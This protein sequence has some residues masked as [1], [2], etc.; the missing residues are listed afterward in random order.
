M[1]E[2]EPHHEWCV[3]HSTKVSREPK[4]KEGLEVSLNS[5]PAAHHSKANTREA[6][7]GG[8]ERLLYAGGWQP[9]EEVD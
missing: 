9:V 3:H 5:G 4:E 6:S 7:V 1:F 2:L 8:K